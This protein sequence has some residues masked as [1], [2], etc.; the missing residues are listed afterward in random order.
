MVQD[1]RAGPPGMMPF[2]SF[3]TCIPFYFVAPL[4]KICQQ[5]R[6]AI[7][8][9]TSALN[10]FVLVSVFIAEGSNACSV[11]ERPWKILPGDR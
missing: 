2:L 4:L 7:C 10:R 11:Q 8:V 1:R 3:S 9:N 5:A 6:I